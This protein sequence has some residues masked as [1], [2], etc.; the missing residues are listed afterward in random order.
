MAKA[1]ATKSVETLKHDDAKRKNIPSAEHQSVL[2]ETQKTPKA[3]R[4]P[5]QTSWGSRSVLRG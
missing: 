1:P 2:E 4:Y 5:R 3:L